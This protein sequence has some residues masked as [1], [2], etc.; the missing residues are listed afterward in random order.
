MCST[1]III[2]CLAT[3]FCG[4]F[5]Q[6]KRLYSFDNYIL[7]LISNASD[8]LK[9]VANNN[10]RVNGN[11]TFNCKTYIFSQAA[12]KRQA[13]KAKAMS[14]HTRQHCL[15]NNQMRMIECF[16]KSKVNKQSRECGEESCSDEKATTANRMC[17]W[18]KLEATQQCVVLMCCCDLQKQSSTTQHRIVAILSLTPIE[19]DLN[20]Y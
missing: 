1:P 12:I 15:K 8:L 10:V 18:G 5:T 14:A 20:M 19:C 4:E 17:K 2:I 3:L 9:G 13:I 6:L 11:Y 16:L 7:L